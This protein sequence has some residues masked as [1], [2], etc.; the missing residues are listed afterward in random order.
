MKKQ[1]LLIITG[2]AWTTA[3]QASM[4]MELEPTT[5][6]SGFV[7]LNKEGIQKS[8]NIFED[9]MLIGQI[10][11]E[12]KKANKWIAS[13]LK[14]NK[15]DTLSGLRDKVTDCTENIT[16]HLKGF[17]ENLS[18]IK[19]N[20]AILD[21]FKK[22]AAYF[23][24]NRDKLKKVV[25]EIDSFTKRTKPT[26]ST[27]KT[28]AAKQEI[29]D[30]LK[31]YAE[32]FIKIAQ[33]AINDFARIDA[34]HFDQEA[35]KAKMRQQKPQAPVAPVARVKSTSEKRKSSSGEKRKSSSG[36]QTGSGNPFVEE[37]KDGDDLDLDIPDIDMDD[38]P[39]LEVP[40]L[41]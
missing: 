7:I 4:E 34:S 20:T 26:L 24:K 37:D 13:A 36:R 27:Q 14:K 18:K 32:T 11:A 2:V 8:P 40:T 25:Q 19:T 41:K 16:G 3:Y 35:L 31:A 23:S 17:N 5:L 10:N 12:K 22:E 33:K 38:L 39:D 6:V 28:E 1:L 30:V 21:M 15:S 9:K 29:A